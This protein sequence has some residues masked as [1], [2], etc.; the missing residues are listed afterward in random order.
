MNDDVR[1]Y[2]VKLSYDVTVEAHDA[3]EANALAYHWFDRVMEQGV[4]DVELPENVHSVQT[5]PQRQIVF[6]G[7]PKVV[8]S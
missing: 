6:V 5:F 1:T 8:T 2:I 4:D 7:G 3:L